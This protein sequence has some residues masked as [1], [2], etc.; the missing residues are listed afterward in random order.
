M[1]QKKT[2]RILIA[3]AG[4]GG[5]TAAMILGRRGYDVEVY[6][7]QPRVGGRNGRVTL[8]NFHFDL[9]PTFLMLKNVLDEVFQ[10]AGAKSED[11]LRCKRLEPM[12][13]L[14]FA[15]QRVE[16][17]SDHAAMQAEIGRLFPGKESTY[18][19]FIA[20][21]RERFGRLYPC[22]QR[23][24]HHFGTLFSLQL[25]RSLPHLALG[26]TLYDV[27]SGYFTDPTL[28]LSFTFQAKYLGM[29]PWECPGLFAIIP[30]IEHEFGI[31]HVYGGLNRIS[32]QMAATAMAQGVKIHLS[33]PVKQLL[34]DGRAVRGFLLEDGREVH[35]DEV[36][37]NA[38]FADAMCSLVPPGA[39]RKY[40]PERLAKKRFSCSTFMLYLGV[41]KIY[42][43]PHHCIVFARDYQANVT[44]IFNGAE[45][46]DDFSFYVHNPSVTDDSLAPAGQ[47]AVYVLV[48]TANLR[49]RI[50]WSRDSQRIRELV[51]DALETRGG[52]PELRRHI[53]AEKMVTPVDWQDSYNVYAGATFNLAHNF[54]QMLYLRPRNKFEEL[55]HCYLV[56]GGTHPGSGLPTIYQS[57]LIAANLISA[58]T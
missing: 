9:G 41:D 15:D 28:S 29:S 18:E 4:P 43:S 33:T 23:P 19:A 57:G 14:Q 40:T 36:I 12:Y 49:G 5:L 27:L 30:Y 35:G 31:Y 51:L 47:S 22:L 10:E 24:Y 3:G 34:L 1:A 38:D 25:L 6:E 54:S 44:G 45:F 48:P 13:R 56:G 42:P 50:D 37:I 8:Q 2:K 53:V 52:M 58:A 16:P 7:K 20:R 26:K 39:L 21:E 55:D 17:T 46:P 11:L 32:E